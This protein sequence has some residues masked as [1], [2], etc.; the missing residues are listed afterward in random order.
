V[1]R[2]TFRRVVNYT[3]LTLFV[4][5]V[6]V[7]AFAYWTAY[8]V[9]PQVD[10]EV[11]APGLKQA[12]SIQRDSRGIPT[13]NASNAEDALFLQGYATAQDRLF[14]MDALRRK[15]AGELSA[16]VGPA[17]FQLDLDAR[18]L[19]LGRVASAHAKTLPPQDLAY[20][21]AYARGV[22]HYIATHR[23]KLPMEFTLLGYDPAP[24]TI[25]DTILAGL[26]MYRSLTTTWRHEMQKQILINASPKRGL[27]ELLYPPRTGGEIAPG[28]NAWAVS[29]KHTATGQPL[30]SNDPHLQ[31]TLPSTW[32]AV[33]IQ[34][35]DLH[36]A[37]V[38]LP[39]VPGVVIGHNEQIAWGVTNLGFDVQDLYDERV[40]PNTLTYEYQGR[41]YPML[42]ELEPIV[43]RGQR[44]ERVN[45]LSTRHGPVMSQ[46][47]QTLA[48]RW[49]AT[50]PGSFQFPFVELNRATNWEQFRAALKRFP[51][52]GQNFVY[53]DKAGNIGYQATGLLPIRTNYAGDVPAQGWS[54]ENEWQG[55]IPF[56]ELPSSFNPADGYV[57][58]ANQNPFPPDYRYP[59]HGDFSTPYRANQIRFMLKDR[60]G[61]K[62]EDMATIQKDVYSEFSL[63]LARHLVQ[64]VDRR[65]PT[66]S[67]LPPAV[68]LLRSW[69]GQMERD[70][71]APL[72][73]SF[74]YQRLK[75]KILDR[76]APA[77]GDAYQDQ[78]SQ[79]V[80]QKFLTERPNGWFED[81]DKTLIAC[82]AES[83][84][85][86]RREQGS[87]ISAWRYGRYNELSIPHPILGRIPLVGEWLG[88]ANVGPVEMA[89]ASTTVKQTGKTIGPSMRF[90]AD[91]NDFN[92]S[93]LD[94]TIGESGN[95]FSP[96]YKDQWETYWS[97]GSSP[98]SFDKTEARHI[99]RLRP[100][101]H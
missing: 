38:S 52:P 80:L 84:E 4:S 97:G 65:K 85:E 27:V 20:I 76:I 68:D 44:L 59:V 25:R 61:S 35:P 73:V 19:R 47:P 82:L 32:H 28:S 16:V 37:G 58:T 24:W 64:A 46:Q 101:Q 11:F 94:L 34:S 2:V 10:G 72:V 88:F 18:Q 100:P 96:H 86:I 95:L 90:T 66:N 55:F 36:V 43:V 93:R 5:T 3:L 98:F 7:G 9:L 75:R 56:E 22:N 26:E 51:G 12:G 17:A 41:L 70:S 89:G 13:I 67:A 83:I 45:V 77:R 21:A 39:G 63:L 60:K 54:G 69:N 33:R 31:W 79:A 71:A 91:L 99:L 92:S 6:A 74:V 57:V 62:A 14:Q 40:P 78:M 8:R 1:D 15:A 30:L 49:T 23:D 81:W 48:M 87:E 29:G 53:A 50:E 42:I